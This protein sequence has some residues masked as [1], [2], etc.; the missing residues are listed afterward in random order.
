MTLANDDTCQYAL[1]W[2][3][4]FPNYIM[5]FTRMSW[6]EVIKSLFVSFLMTVEISSRALFLFL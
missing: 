5:F 3:H 4:M 1:E 6:R 2:S